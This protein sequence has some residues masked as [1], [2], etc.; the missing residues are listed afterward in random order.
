MPL[1]TAEK[2]ANTMSKIRLAFVAVLLLGF[3]AAALRAAPPPG[4]AAEANL[5]VL[6]DAIRANRKA[7]VAINLK[8]TDDQA[9]KFW[10]VYDR[11]QQEIN[12][13]GDRL[14]GVIK[15]YSA[16]FSDLSN[17]KAVKLME[18][19]LTIEAERVKV[20]RTYIDEFAKILPGR[21]VARF[22][23]IENKI[24]AVIRYDLAATIPVVEEPSGVSAK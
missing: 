23:Q 3:S 20:R 21:T 14:V 4:G 22:Y 17:D 24:D 16:S 9:A 18:E 19:Y 11:Y 5:D 6:L 8:L 13:L 12:G 15:D 1:R 10:P 7:L 2:G